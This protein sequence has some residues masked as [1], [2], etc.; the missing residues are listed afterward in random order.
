MNIRTSHNFAKSPSQT[1]YDNAQ[2]AK[3]G[4]SFDHHGRKF[5]A[6]RGSMGAK[7]PQMQSQ[8]EVNVMVQA[9]SIDTNSRNIQKG[10]NITFPTID[11]HANTINEAQMFNTFNSA[12]SQLPN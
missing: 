4:L 3:Q 10:T 11:N 8:E 1:F 5:N 9:T 7:S 2:S 6:K 12:S